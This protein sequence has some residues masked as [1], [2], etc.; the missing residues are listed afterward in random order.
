[1]I[2]VDF[3]QAY[4]CILGQKWETALLTY[5]MS[6]KKLIEVTTSH[7]CSQVKIR[8]ELKDITV[9]RQGVKQCDRLAPHLFGLALQ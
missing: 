9:T 4:D 7:T 8:Y 1:M 3:K 2:F 6:V 5:G